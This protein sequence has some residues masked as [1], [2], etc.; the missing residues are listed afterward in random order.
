M[1]SKLF[2]LIITFNVLSHVTL[3][4]PSKSGMAVYMENEFK[5]CR[6]KEGSK[7]SN[8]ELRDLNDKIYTQNSSKGKVILLS[9][10]FIACKG[11][12]D[13]IKYL[14]QINEYFVNDTNIAVL[15]VSFDETKTL[16]ENIDKIGI[17]YRVCSLPRDEIQALKFGGGYPRYILLGPDNSI[18]KFG[19]AISNKNGKYID[20]VTEIIDL[21][22]ILELND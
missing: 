11:C 4:Q 18:A 21:I 6:E 19:L 5:K 1:R 14:N 16:R 7:F 2:F 13:E 12:R 9:F 17:N 10:W 3:A 20:S 8:Y 22:N 15:G